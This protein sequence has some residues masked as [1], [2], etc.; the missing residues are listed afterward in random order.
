MGDW[1]KT[2]IVEKKHKK[3]REGTRRDAKT[4]TNRRW[5][6]IYADGFVMERCLAS[7]VAKAMEDKCEADATRLY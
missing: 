4:K 3:N 7:S 5:T 1:W 2:F 6:Q